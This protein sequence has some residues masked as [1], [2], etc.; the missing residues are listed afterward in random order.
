MENKKDNISSLGLG[1]RV[2]TLVNLRWIAVLG[3]TITCFIVHY[4]LNF[5]LPWTEVSLTILALAISNFALYPGYSINNRLNET[6]TTFVIAADIIQLALMIFFTGGLSNPFVVLLT[7]F[8]ISL[9]DG[10]VGK[11][12]IKLSPTVLP[13]TPMIPVRYLLESVL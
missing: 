13:P 9:F 3:Q 8:S 10:K 4:F 11:P 7:S 12:A 2:K 5:E 6:S 1:I